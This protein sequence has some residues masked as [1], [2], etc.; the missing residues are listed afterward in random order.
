MVINCFLHYYISL[1]LHC[2]YIFP[3]I[4]NMYLYKISLHL[5]LHQNKY[6]NF[7]GHLNDLNKFIPKAEK[8]HNI[9][10]AI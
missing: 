3:T 10:V 4:T 5:Y 7:F 9:V 2:L 1:I 6:F 8:R